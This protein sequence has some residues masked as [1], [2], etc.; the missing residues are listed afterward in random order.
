MYLSIR[1]YKTNQAKEFT[2][3]VKEGWIPLISKVPGFISYYAI[4]TA[5]GW[6]SVSIFKDKPG[7]RKLT[8]WPQ[9]G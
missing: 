6:A 1:Q 7:Q 5:D 3:R 9:N 8:G 2:K 4:E